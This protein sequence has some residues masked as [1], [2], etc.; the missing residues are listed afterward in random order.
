M[1]SGGATNTVTSGAVILW[2]GASCS[3]GLYPRNG[4]G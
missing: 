1:I 2:T 4:V 3:A